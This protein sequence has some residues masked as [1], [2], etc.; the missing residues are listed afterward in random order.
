MAN[1]GR[2]VFSAP[3]KNLNPL[4]GNHVTGPDG[5]CEIC[6]KLKKLKKPKK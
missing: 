4:L 1:K 2:I 5:K 6:E 3:R